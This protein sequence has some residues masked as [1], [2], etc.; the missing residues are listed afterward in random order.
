MEILKDEDKFEIKCY[1]GVCCKNTAMTVNKYF[2]FLE[3]GRKIPLWRETIDCQDCRL[4]NRM[5][6]LL[7]M[8]SAEIKIPVKSDVYFTEQVTDTYKH[9]VKYWPKSIGSEFL[10]D[11]TELGAVNQSG[12]RCEDLTKLS[13]LD[14]SFDAL[15]TMDVIEHVPDYLKG[16]QES[17]RVLRPD[18]QLVLSAPFNLDLESSLVRARFNSNGKIDHI[19]EPE[20]HGDPLDPNGLLCFTTFGWDF[21]QTLR[22]IGFVNPCL[23]FYWSERFGYLGVQYCVLARKPAQSAS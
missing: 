23:S 17:F 22:D 20:Y 1:C 4:N 13:F 3:G 18:G 19:M 12:I 21:L 6:A 7:H 2:S 15:V 8:M 10:R 16:L 5:R 14:E 9:A 11:G